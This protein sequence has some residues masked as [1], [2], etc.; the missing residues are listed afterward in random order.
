MV[1]EHRPIYSAIRELLRRPAEKARKQLISVHRKAGTQPIGSDHFPPSKDHGVEKLPELS[2]DSVSS[3]H[4][5][6]YRFSS[7]SED[8]GRIHNESRSGPH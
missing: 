1:R 8:E 6:R 7:L 5:F 2:S 3:E 4:V